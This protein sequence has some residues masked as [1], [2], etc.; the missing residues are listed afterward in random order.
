MASWIDTR[1]EISGPMSG[2]D[3]GEEAR[4]M[5]RMNLANLEG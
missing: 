5:S 3:I 4:Q 2:M 1:S